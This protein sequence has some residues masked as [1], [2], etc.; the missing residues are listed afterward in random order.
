[1]RT[2]GVYLVSFAL[3]ILLVGCTTQPV[4]TAPGLAATAALNQQA[5]TQVRVVEADPGISATAKTELK[6]VDAT[7]AA[8]GKQIAIDQKQAAQEAKAYDDLLAK[9]DSCKWLGWKTKE[10]LHWFLFLL[11]TGFIIE[12]AGQSF[13]SPY[14]IIARVVGGIFSFGITEID[15]LLAE[16]YAGVAWL[17]KW[18]SGLIASIH[19]SST[20]AVATGTAVVAP[21]TS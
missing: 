10:Y 8:E 2:I 20:P 12:A 11:V 18:V 7:L 19:I 3:A 14:S 21:Q 6:T 5:I 1:M 13:A 4:N 17:V 16:C 9:Y 15:S